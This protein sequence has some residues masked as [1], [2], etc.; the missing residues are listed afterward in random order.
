MIK[1][2]IALFMCTILAAS[3]SSCGSI[4]DDDNFSIVCTIFPPYDFAT[5]ITKGCEN[6]SVT[7]LLKSG[8]ESHEFDPTAT[9]IAAIVNAD[10]FI[11][12]GGESDSWVEDIL[13]SVSKDTYCIKMMEEVSLC[14]EEHDHEEHEHEHTHEYDEHVWTSPKNAIEITNAISK[15][16]V[17]K[18]PS[19]KDKIDQNT[20]DYVNQ[21]NSLDDDFRSAV[22]IGNRNTIVVADRFPLLYFANE[23]SLNYY[24]AFSG[25]A[26]SVEPSAQ[27]LI[28][29]CEA[30]KEHSVP[31]VFK[32]EL[33][34]GTT[35]KYV[36][37]ETGTKVL[38]F[39]SCHNR[40]SDEV[41]TGETYISLMK[42]NLVN[43]KEAL[44]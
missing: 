19:C 14:E 6:V 38:E 18:L 42:R 26:T 20:R 12:N 11:Y 33:S 36:A 25:C 22:E 23:Y 39:H 2:I 7:Q 30:V 34:S 28:N 32:M 21:L 3:L 16:V 13:K 37:N 35:A 15:A 29:L 1:R 17:E 27:T 44:G 41:N 40:T 9:D 4:K 10:I 24:A 43:L 8:M 31:V 5:Q